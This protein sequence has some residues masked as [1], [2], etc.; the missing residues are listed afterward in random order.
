M[1]RKKCFV[2][3]NCMTQK[4]FRFIREELQKTQREMGLLLGL[5]SRG[6]QSFE[7][8]WRRVPAAVERQMLF[9]YSLKCKRK[10]KIKSC[11]DFHRCP[12]EKRKVCPAWESRLGRLC[13]FITGT[14]CRGR[15]DLT[16]GRKILECRK[17]PVFR[18]SFPVS[19]TPPRKKK[20][21]SKPER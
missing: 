14:L 6:V 11:W 16:W 2:G 3:K 19:D 7:Q 17:C 8:G 5:S 18:E 10:R 13:W 9:F 20:F 15:Q 4:E 21:P 1:S 12:P